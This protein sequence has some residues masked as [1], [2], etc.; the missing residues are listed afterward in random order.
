MLSDYETRVRTDENQN[1]AGLIKCVR[2]IAIYQILINL[3][4]GISEFIF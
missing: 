1:G 4:T 3:E 2:M